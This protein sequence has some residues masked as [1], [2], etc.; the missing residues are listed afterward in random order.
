MHQWWLSHSLAYALQG[1]NTLSPRQNGRSFADE[2]WKCIF[3]NEDMWTSINISLRLDSKVQIDNIPALIQIMVWRRSD[4]KPLS[5]PIMISLL[6]HIRAL[7]PQWVDGLLLW[8]RDTV[9]WC[10]NQFQNFIRN[11][12]DGRLVFNREPLKMLIIFD[13]ILITLSVAL[14]CRIGILPNCL[15]IY[16]YKQLYMSPHNLLYIT[17]V[18]VDR[19]VST[20]FLMKMGADDNKLMRGVFLY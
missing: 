19:F 4:D 6:M 12:F 11:I 10:Y 18:R 7:S 1:F 2:I 5:E 15:Y 13:G 8:T 14:C 9:L 20:E 16:I 3:L 17:F